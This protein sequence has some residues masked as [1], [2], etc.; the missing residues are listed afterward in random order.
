MRST[1]RIETMVLPE[2]SRTVANTTRKTVSRLARKHTIR[3]HIQYRMQ[4]SNTFTV[5]FIFCP[6]KG[7]TWRLKNISCNRNEPK[8]CI[9]TWQITK[10]SSTKRHADNS[11][12]HADLW[13][14]EFCHSRSYSSTVIKFDLITQHEV[15]F[16]NTSEATKRSS[17][18]TENGKCTQICH[19][20]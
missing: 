13:P 16:I 7:N 12:N 2:L 9:N 3:C 20:Q 15:P 17:D 18:R 19:E 1:W 14:L 4:V 6:A 10:V 5:N 8:K 11:R